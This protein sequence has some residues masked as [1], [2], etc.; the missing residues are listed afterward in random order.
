MKKLSSTF[1]P[2]FKFFVLI[3]LLFLSWTSQS[4]IE[5]TGGDQNPYTPQNLIQNVLLGD[6]V[7]VLDSDITYSGGAS[8]VGF[9]QN[10]LADIGIE[11]GIVM[12][13]GLAINGAQ[14]FATLA[15]DATSG[16]ANDADL[17]AIGATISPGADI[18]DAAI[19]EITFIP[20]ADT[21]R[22]KY[23][24]ASEEY[25]TYPCTQFN[26]V[27]GFFIS[28]PNPAGGTYNAE[29]IA[30]VPDPAD[31]SGFTFTNTPVAISSVHAANG[32]GCPAEFEEY[33]N[34][35]NG[36][37]TLV[38]GAYLDVFTA[39]AIVIPCEP[40]TIKLAIADLGDQILNSTVFL[41][42][43]SFGTGKLEVTAQTV[44]LDGTLVEGCA[45][46]ELCFQIPSPAESDI[47]LDYNFIGT[48]QNGVDFE[49]IPMDLFI[50]AGDSSVCYP[51]IPILDG[52]S[53]PLDSLGIDVQIDPCTRDTFWITIQDP[54]LP[55][56]VLPNDTTF[57]QGD[58]MF[59]DATLPVIL[60]DPPTFTNN[61]SIPI[62]PTNEPIFSDIFVSGVFP[63]TLQDGVVKSVCI[64]SL[65]HR[66]ADDL[67]VFLFSPSG[68]FIELFTDVGADC[69]DYIS[70]C[71]T[72]SATTELT[73]IIPIGTDCAAGQPTLFTG[74][75]AIEG[76]W[77]DLWS[78]EGPTNGVWRLFVLDDS[79]G[80]NGDLHS[81]TICFEPAYKIEYS[82]SPSAGLSCDDCPDPVVKPDTTTTY[83]LTVTDTYGCS[84]QDSITVTIDETLPP[85][86]VECGT[87]TSNSITFTWNDIGAT[88]GYEVNIDG[89]GWIPANG[90]LEHIVN[91]LVLNQNV[92]IEVRGIGDCNG[93]IG[94]IDCMTPDCP[95]PTANI[96]N[97]VNNNCF[98]DNIGTATVTGMG[99]NPPFIYSMNSMVDADGIFTNLPAGDY[100]VLVIDN[101]NCSFTALFTITEPDSLTSID[102]VV[103][104]VQCFGATN[105]QGTVTLVGG[106]LPYSYVWSS[107]S[108][109]SVATDLVVGE[110]YVTVT[111]GGG[112]QVI[113]TITLTQPDI[114]EVTLAADSIACFMGLDGTASA[115]PIGGTEPY[116]YVWSN[117]DTGLQAT[118]LNAQT[119]TVT[120]TDAN[121]CMAIGSIT[122][123]EHDALNLTITS[124]TPATCNGVQDGTATVEPSGGAGGYT[125]AW[126]VL[127]NQTTQTAIGLTV[128]TY[129]VEVM[130]QLGC[131]ATTTVSVASP[132]AIVAGYNSTPTN[133]FDSADGQV[134]VTASGGTPDPNLPE[135]YTYT[136]SEP[137][138]VDNVH[139]LLPAG[140]H[141]VT[142]TDSNNCFEVLPIEVFAPAEM[143]VGITSNNVNCANGIDG[144]ATIQVISGGTAG[145]NYQWSAGTNPNNPTVTGLAAGLVYVTVEDALGCIKIDS[146]EIAEPTAID[147]SIDF[148]PV[149]CNGNN[150]GTASVTASN[151][152]GDFTYVW[153]DPVAQTIPTATDLVAGD[154]TVTVTDM[155]MCTSTT[156]ITVTEPMVLS[157]TISGNDAACFGE[158]TGNITVTPSGG[159]VAADYTYQW[160]DPNNQNTGTANTLMAQ[161]SPYYVTITD[162]N[163]CEVI[164]SFIVS[165]PTALTLELDSIDVLCFGENGG[166]ATAL[167]NGGGG[168]YNYAWSDGASQSTMIATGL[169][170]DTYT[171]T[172]TDANNCTIEQSITVNEPTEIMLTQEII[173]N[174]NCN[175]SNTGA[176][177]L[178]VTGGAPPYDYSWSSGETSLDLAALVVGSYT[179]TITDFNNCELTQTFIL[180]E[181]SV[182]ELSFTN[183]NIGCFMGV[184]GSIDLTVTGGIVGTYNIEWTGPNGF[185]STQEDL[186]DLV[187]GQYAIVVTD[188]NGCEVNELIEITQPATGVT[189]S[190]SDPMT[191]CFGA[192][193]GTATVTAN[194]GTPP[195]G[196]LWNDPIGQTTAVANNLPPGTYTVT[197]SDQSG[198]TFIE[199]AEIFEQPEI[200]IVLSQTSAFCF[201]GNEGTATVDN[202]L[203]GGNPANLDDFS[204]QWSTNPPQTS[205][206]ASNL[207]GGATVNVFVLDALGCTS[208]ASIVIDNPESVQAAIVDA[209]DVVCF[210]GNDG[211]ATVGGNG[212]VTPYT[213]FWSPNANSQ[214]TETATNLSTGNYIVTVTDA[215][216]CM[217][218]TTVEIVE[219]TAMSI[220]NFSVRSVEC[221]GDNTGSL[222]P[223]LD[224]GNTPYS[225]NWSNGE[226]TAEITSLF[227]GDYTLTVTDANGC[228][229]VNSETIRQPE[230]ALTATVDSDDVNCAGGFD[231]QI[232][233]FPSGGTPPYTYSIDGT[234]FNGSPTQIGLMAG[235]YNNVTIRDDKG[236]EV[237]LAPLT[238]FEPAGIEVDLGPDTTILFGANIFL[239]PQIN[240]AF[241]NVTYQ[242]LP[243]DNENLNCYDCSVVLVD[244]LDNQ[245]SYEVVVTDENGCTAS[246]LITIFV[247]KF[248]EIEVPTGFSPNGDGN[249]DLLLV[250]GRNGTTVTLF[251]VFDRWGEMV[252]EYRN[253]DIND[254]TIGWDGIFDGVFMNPGVYIWYLE[255]E[256]EDGEETS[257]KGQTT[258]IR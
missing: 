252:Y 48:A 154:Y 81:W 159:T 2:F 198:C 133:C 210:G 144:D 75:F 180:D 247:K 92:T 106:T 59:I 62:E 13:S 12:S 120:V 241:G 83:V 37:N 100:E 121:N 254:E 126:Q 15:S 24:F 112:C 89:Q 44:S 69:D 1:Q 257:L 51:I 68:Q 54:T 82:W 147:L 194:G 181:P 164:D 101:V 70:S 196:Y 53:E 192:V 90:L 187:A 232:F 215:N 203:Y 242:W 185:T 79:N 134:V 3:P 220:S 108:L 97:L 168:G 246:D 33:Y 225:Y 218:T 87:I 109:D 58:S 56:V 5:I 125:Y 176:I 224:G 205:T 41:E 52:L 116:T 244:S 25:P 230:N 216:G 42:A 204:I 50:A 145:Y 63:L 127:G 240:N 233:L 19:Y 174:V 110:N 77:S 143:V 64:D 104:D 16:T 188:A 162:D 65:T 98:G 236:C 122:L 21:L 219:P 160:S 235:D 31:P 226:T 165:S 17:L 138:G 14:P 86:V 212:G 191:I 158:A 129:T 35:N 38:Y 78:S 148:T 60:P 4:Q 6:G 153:S 123:E 8:S 189:I 29:N 57:C 137:G 141:F 115:Q 195:Y 163:G 132:N 73:D 211:T 20:T 217:S 45:Q 111:D 9:F 140:D 131:T 107:G 43:K 239:S 26:D 237:R 201:N 95:A 85:P 105:G 255:A 249:N 32:T 207:Q 93:Q 27:F 136:W 88:G 130:D 72:P 186:T 206:T 231:G 258:L 66:W 49:T 183:Q 30:L 150:T 102:V 113:D 248:R 119:F 161:A 184:D 245:Q 46:G 103:D 96:T 208:Q 209:S 238:I 117:G 222:N 28:G 39:Q 227:A 47:I 167:A 223:I 151:G 243:S 251:R 10:G 221:F 169:T 197:V 139:N 76:V 213:Y 178:E 7:E 175:G 172:V 214:E 146:I 67:D 142:I 228:T 149:D 18:N 157:S 36:S 155:N 61:T 182:L 156:S 177:D 256:F 199:V 135:G 202:I 171:V 118:N 11:R 253:F 190:I 229:V 170:A 94:T 80:F 128:G 40:Y 234:E 124:S 200:S 152:A 173:T 91:G 166:S 99:A 74:D 179:I 71:F 84:T 22:F 55:D 250:H 114:L 193:D 34:P 23:V